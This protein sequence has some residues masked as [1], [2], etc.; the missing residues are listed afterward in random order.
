MCFI[1]QTQIMCFQMKMERAEFLMRQALDLDE[2]G[3]EDEAVEMYMESAEL[4]LELVSHNN[5]LMSGTKFFHNDLKKS[6]FGL[7]IAIIFDV[8]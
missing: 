8:L 3:Q 4:C 2:A 1:T 7:P 6:S 5:F